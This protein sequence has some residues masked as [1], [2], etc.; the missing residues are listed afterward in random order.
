MIL[1]LVFEPEKILEVTSFK[2][3]CDLALHPFMSKSSGF[4]GLAAQV[5]FGSSTLKITD[6]ML[7]KKVFT[8][9]IPRVLR[10]WIKGVEIDWI[11]GMTRMA[12]SLL[13]C[14]RLESLTLTTSFLVDRHTRHIRSPGDKLNNGSFMRKLVEK[15]PLA[16]KVTIVDGDVNPAR[17]GAAR[18]ST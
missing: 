1:K 8:K 10:V 3:L 4:S 9:H 12:D 6:Q 13:L 2:Q 17:I 11:E 16:C 14:T 15:L 5:V 18:D 7:A